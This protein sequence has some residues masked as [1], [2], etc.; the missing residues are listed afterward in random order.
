MRGGAEEHRSL[1][2]GDIKLD[3]EVGLEFLEYNERQTKTRT[4]AGISQFRQ[5]P[6][7]YQTLDQAGRFRE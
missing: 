5:K 2:W 7:M 3:S 6:R 1:C 4:G